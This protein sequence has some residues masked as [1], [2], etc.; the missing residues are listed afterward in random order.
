MFRRVL[1]VFDNEHP[2]PE[3]LG[4]ARDFARR[5]DA[6]VTVLMLVPMS[7]VGRIFL[8]AQRKALARIETRA[9]R[10]LTR[11]IA[12]FIHQ[13]SEVASALKVGEPSQ[14]LL[15][16]LA[17]RPPFQAIIWGSGPDLP[18]RGHWINRVSGTLE[19]PLLTVSRKGAT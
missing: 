11:A 2:C 19:C 1:I 6:R 3:S 16:F 10:I 15:K 4:Y 13:G 14:E 9:E 8:G 5:M 7:F 17:D 12:D 18:G